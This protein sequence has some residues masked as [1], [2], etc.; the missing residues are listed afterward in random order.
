MTYHQKI[1]KNMPF[2]CLL[3]E[4]REGDFVI[5]EPNTQFCKIT[6]SNEE[7]LKGKLIEEVF[8][9][10]SFS[11]G[12]NELVESFKIAFT[13]QEPHKIDVLRY[14]LY[15]K[16]NDSY[17]E[18]YW[19]I[20]NIPLLDE[21]FES[22]YILNVVK[23]IT[24]EVLES[25]RCD[26]LQ[27]NLDTK[28]ENHEEFIERITDGLFSLDL[29]GNFVSLNK[30]FID[31]AEI[32]ESELLKMNFLPFCGQDHR[33]IIVK[34]FNVAIGGKNQKFE[35]N[36]ISGKGRNMVLEI[37]LVPLKN[38]G[39]ITGLYGIAKDISR[40]K[41]SENALLQSERKFKALVQQ[42][43][44]LIGILDLE[45][46]YKFVS[47]TSYPVLG[48]TQEELIGKTA[49]DFIHPGDKERVI[50]Q[51]SEL[52]LK[53]Q[54]EIQPFRFKSAKGEWR[55]IETKATNLA[56]DPSVDGIVTNSRDV[57]EHINSQKAIKESEERYRSFFEN[58]IDAVMVTIPDGSIL[59]ANPSACKMFQ[60]TEEEL[61]LLGRSAV[62]DPM[63]PRL[64]EALK[65]RRETG[66]A[67]M[68]LTF[69]RKDGSKFPGEIT[70]SI[71]K[72]A[73][74][75]P[76]S[77]LILRDVTERK[78]T[79]NNLLKLNK[80]LKNYTKEL[81]AANEGLE[82][83]SY[84]VSHNLRAPIANIIGVADLLEKSNQP[85]EIRKQLLKEIFNNIGRLDNV[86]QDL[87]ETLKLNA[88]LSKKRESVNLESLTQNIIAS[89]QNLIDKENVSI[90]TDFGAIDK[91]YTVKSYLY[92]AFFNLISNSIKYRKPEVSPVIE[93]KTERLD[94]QVI[95]HFKDNGLGIDLEK[96]RDQIFGFYKRFH[97]HVEGRG[98]G[99][100][101]VKSQLVMLGG[102]IKVKSS[103]GH[104]TEF[105]I[106]LQ[107]NN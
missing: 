86:M 45:G 81:F 22:E 30:G 9:Q 65:L 98:L 34:K 87:N 60:R 5:K 14:D 2:P 107:Y 3:F 92:N 13:S 94:D 39:R 89:N 63:D 49:F 95:I 90:I 72:D 26:V 75:N 28:T 71:F 73:N 83:F 74:G 4:R 10:N 8:P 93:I 70:S 51:F 6:N 52:E 61:C 46:K 66:T 47:E 21:N 35:A 84:I 29:E 67:S 41:E 77:S 54:I 19:E 31:I 102:Q 7:E 59:A 62:T 36:F 56:N 44:D 97:N 85:E 20:E 55:W 37:S 80:E 32:P 50:N 82:Q 68:E 23:D 11:L 69:V 57:T 105:T 33:E 100:F 18:K 96:K 17:Q 78:L 24:F 53:K 101:M 104:G 25:E 1:F 64:A 15:D 42:G 58:S 88:E 38:D 12:L 106:Y 16:Q 43:S 79:E 40:L 76:R 48:F 91:V 99:L 27:Y 103:L